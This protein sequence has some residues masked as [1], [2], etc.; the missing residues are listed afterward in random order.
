MDLSNLIPKAIYTPESWARLLV[1]LLPKGAIWKHHVFFQGGVWVGSTL[2]VLLSVFGS[3]IARVYG[4]YITLIKEAVP[5]LSDDLLAEWE[6]VAGLPDACTPLSQTEDERRAAVH[7]HITQGK[8]NINMAE[9]NQSEQ[10]WIDYAANLGYTIDIGYQ[11]DY[12]RVGDRVGE[13]LGD[14]ESLYTWVIAGDADDFLKC[15]FERDKPAYTK[16]VW[17]T[18]TQSICNIKFTVSGT[19]KSQGGLVGNLTLSFTNS[20]TL[21]A[22]GALSG[23]GSVD[24]TTTG[25][26]AAKGALSGSIDVNFTT[27]GTLNP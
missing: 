5:G 17:S 19:L 14:T 10:F 21:Q 20:G 12:F 24:I 16:I 4:L 1:K 3:E 7:Q 8:G 13:R 18:F 23:A 25:T 11:A 22:M 27:T 15:L 2:G 9:L 6:S 26:V